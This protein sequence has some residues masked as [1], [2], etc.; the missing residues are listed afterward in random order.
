VALPDPR[1]LAGEP[2]ALDLL[3]TEH[4]V[5]GTP[6]DLLA[7]AATAAAWLHHAVGPDVAADAAAAMGGAPHDVV[8]PLVEA[9]RAIRAVVEAAARPPDEARGALNRV[10]ARGRVVARLGD[11]GPERAVEADPGWRPAV[12]A[13][14]DLLALLEGRP[15]RVRRCAHDRCALWFLDTSRSGGRL[16]CSMATC[17]N[18]A[19]AQRH[20]RRSRAG[21]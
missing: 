12:L 2:L 20:Y 11:D 14:L 21:G 17:G 19:K 3:D 7:D 4:V 10:L 13:A 6:V 1:P 15:D 5:D 8:A 16:W 18:R 9:R